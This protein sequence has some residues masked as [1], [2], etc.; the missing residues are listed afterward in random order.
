VI[1]ILIS[2]QF[3]HHFDDFR[4]IGKDD[5]VAILTALRKMT[6]TLWDRIHHWHHLQ[7]SNGCLA[8]SGSLLRLGKIGSVTVHLRSCL[9]WKQITISHSDYWVLT[10]TLFLN[11]AEMIANW[12]EWFWFW[13]SFYAW[14]WFEIVW[15][16]AILIWFSIIFGQTILIFIW[17]RFRHDFT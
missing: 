4:L 1:L 8:A 11:I 10:T 5:T 16:T 9:C 6:C 17:N 14:F 7:Q 2:N 15:R 12:L 3:L 13:K